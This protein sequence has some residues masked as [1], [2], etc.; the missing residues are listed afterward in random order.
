VAQSET[1]YLIVGAGAVG[2]AFADTLIDEDP[3]CHITIVDKHARPGGHWNDAYSFVKLHQP[4]ATYGVNS[5]ELCP[6][7]VDLHGHNK[8]MYPLATRS[9]IL[10]YYERLMNDRLI[11]SGRVRYIP[12][13]EYREGHRIRQ[14]FSGE[15]TPV[16]VRR[17]LVDATWFQTSVPA[18]HK[19]C[20]EIAEGARL[21]VPG[22]LPKLWREADNLPEHYIVLGA[23]KTAMD[24]VVWL[25]EA[26]VD[27]GRI[28]WVR[29]R[30]S[31]MFNRR[32]LQPAHAALEGLIHFQEALVLAAASSASG[33]EMLAKLGEQNIMLRI[34]PDVA[35][36]MF[37]YAVISEGE[38][39]MLRQVRQVYRGGRVSRIEP[40]RMLLGE[41]AE[42]VPENTL[43]IDCTATAVP[44][45]KRKDTG[46]FFNGD[47]ITLQ[48]AM[49]PFVPY[50]AALAA[51]LEANFD[52]DEEKNALVPSAPLTDTTATYPA[53]V[54]ANLISTGLLG[55]NP[56]TN[57][58]NARS[59][60]H[61]TGPAIAELVAQGSPRL[62]RL[63]QAGKTIAENMPGVIR[64]GIQAQALHEAT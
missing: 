17:K 1:D 8:G 39:D 22:D 57:A 63:Q 26:G 6:N 42:Q 38:I 35:P 13:A 56:K 11:P 54:M 46:P 53:A 40:G 58:F 33:D 55:Q 30:D 60:L 19:P 62:A 41:R 10:A 9:E 3:D 27:P 61:P 52:S 23:G 47:R 34:D 4:S 15:E 45:S 51:F 14:I 36:S 48:L 37:H 43:F 16:T 24:T 7:R 44:F 31:W 5:M 64:L 29:P 18:T 50:S 49:V 20:F 32:F 12:L 2:L 25:I 21:A 28:G 59:R